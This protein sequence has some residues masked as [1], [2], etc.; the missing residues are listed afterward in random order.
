MPPR[1]PM[2][3]HGTSGCRRGP[4]DAIST[5]AVSRSLWARNNSGRPGDPVSSPVSITIRTLKPRLPRSAS[6]ASIAAM[7]I[8]CWLLLSADPRP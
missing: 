2:N 6:T 5:S 1:A 7:L 3:M 8:R 4:S